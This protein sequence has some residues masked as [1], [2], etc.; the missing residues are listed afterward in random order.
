MCREFAARY[1]EAHKREF[2][3]LASSASGTSRTSPWIPHDEAS[4]AGAFID[5]FEKDYVYR[6]L[7]PVYWCIYDRTA[8]AEAEVEYEDHTS[9]SIWVKFPVVE[10]RKSATLGNDVSGLI[11]TTTPWT[12]PANRALAFHPEFEYVVAETPAGKLLLAKE[13]LTSLRG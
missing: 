4:I 12:L 3:R 7:K 10:S 5:F 1:V 6:G 11:W 8:L 2:K 13:R 9:P